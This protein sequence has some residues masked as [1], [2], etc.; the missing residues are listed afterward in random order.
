MG[1]GVRLSLLVHELIHAVGLDNDEHSPDDV[2]AAIS[3]VI[4]K[5]QYLK[6]GKQAAEDLVQPPDGSTPLPPIRIGGRTLTNLKKA[7]TGGEAT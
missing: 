5:G 2:F 3:V 7:W 4:P 6:S 1:P